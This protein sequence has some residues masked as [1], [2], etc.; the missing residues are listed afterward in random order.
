MKI[1]ATLLLS[2]GALSG[3]ANAPYSTGPMQLGVD[4]YRVSARA[5]FGTDRSQS[6]K[7]AFSE[8]QAHC[9]TMSKE[10]MVS[11]T[12]DTGV[13]PYEVTY[14]CLNKGDPALARPN[15]QK[16]PDTVIQVK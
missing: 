7:L 1:F 16:T 11:G 2:A 15:L 14:L 4:T 6:H 5:P 13:G 9:K 12:R 8:A 3:C 10:L